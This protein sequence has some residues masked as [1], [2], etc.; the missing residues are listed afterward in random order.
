VVDLNGRELLQGQLS[1][2]KGESV[3]D[4]RNL[5]DGIYIIGIY[6]NGALKLNKKLVVQK[7][8]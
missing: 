6:N 5:K 7:A 2:N 3:I 1:S 8:N 4:T